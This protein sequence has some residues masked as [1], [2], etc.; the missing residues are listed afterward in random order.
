[1]P[2]KA[3]G[4]RRDSKTRP[5]LAKSCS[6]ESGLEGH[7]A[8]RLKYR[9]WYSSAKLS[10]RPENSTSVNVYTISAVR[11]ILS[12]M[13][14]YIITPWRNRRELLDVRRAFYP[15]P[16]ISR[17]ASD[18][19]RHEAVEL[20]SVWVQRGNCPHSI[21]STAL[22]VSALLNEAVGT[23]AYAIRAAYS[24]AFSR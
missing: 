14:Q 21:E 7:E 15:T 24:A 2:D 18:K 17:A 6:A 5:C 23:S 13:V 16:E 11:Y 10:T 20:V 22:L 4:H 19:E 3:A 9:L 1:M 8:V 12:K